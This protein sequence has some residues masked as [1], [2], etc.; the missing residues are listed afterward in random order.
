MAQWSVVAAVA[1]GLGFALS[2]LLAI[3]ASYATRGLSYYC[4]QFLEASDGTRQT[5]DS[6]PSSQFALA[7]LFMLGLADLVVAP[8][9]LRVRGSFDV[10]SLEASSSCSY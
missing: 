6:H 4:D 5:A 8:R 2:A 9:F 3:G 10:L 1:A 7:A